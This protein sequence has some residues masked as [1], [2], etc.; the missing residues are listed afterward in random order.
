MLS[1]M[2]MLEDTTIVSAMRFPKMKDTYNW[3]DLK[4][5]L[6]VVRGG[7]LSAATKATGVSSPTLSRRMTAFEKRIGQT[8]F[9]RQQRGYRLTQSGEQLLSRAEEAEKA[10]MSI[11]RWRHGKKNARVIRISA[12]TWTSFYLARNIHRIW[13]EDDNFS[14]EFV[15]TESRVDIGRRAAE[16]GIRN[17]RPEEQ[18]LAGRKIGTVT[19]AAYCRKE[20]VASQTGPQKWIA[21]T[22][23]G[24]LTPSG[25]WLAANHADQIVIQ[26]NNP[27]CA[28]GLAGAGVGRVVLPC[29]IGDL[30][31]ALE[32]A[33]AP[34]SELRHDQWLVCHH[35]ERNERVVKRVLNRIALHIRGDQELFR[36]DET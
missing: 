27:F 23:S 17:H 16:I 19:F 11:D 30:E 31:E 1:R 14:I 35:E 22:G 7:G 32:R 13:N 25:R 28:L 15:T 3:N 6:A 24:S 2:T 9:V 34:I 21:M 12:G 8:L 4:L 5:F 20:A 36:G 33:S 18:W 10:I 29:F 26:A